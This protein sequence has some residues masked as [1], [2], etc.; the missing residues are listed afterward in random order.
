MTQLPLTPKSRGFNFAFLLGGIQ[1]AI[2]EEN[3]QDFFTQKKEVFP[4]N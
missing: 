4:S 1:E 3:L 2:L